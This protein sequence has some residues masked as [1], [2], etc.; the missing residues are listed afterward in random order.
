MKIE[1]LM[2]LWLIGLYPLDLILGTLVSEIIN[3]FMD[4]FINKLIFFYRLCI[5]LK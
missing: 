3:V 1:K 2:P 5:K 4:I